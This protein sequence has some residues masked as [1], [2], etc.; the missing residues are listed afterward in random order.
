MAKLAFS[1]LGLKVKTD[2]IPVQ[3]GEHTV[4]VK[5]YL[6]ITEKMELISNVINNSIDP[7]TNF[8]NKGRVET[9]FALEVIYHY[10]NLSFTDKMKE[11][12]CKLYDILQSN[13]V[14]PKICVLISEELNFL[15]TCLYNTIDSIVKHRNSALGI[16]EAIS[17]DYS[18][19]NLD[20]TEIQQKLADPDNMALLKD[21]LSKLG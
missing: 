20:A 12:P 1:K 15:Y 18:N 9:F 17:A 4:E 2:T 5:T 11:D 16:L 7:D 3:M 14:Y 21:V 8:I 19:L 6:P 13:N 10:T